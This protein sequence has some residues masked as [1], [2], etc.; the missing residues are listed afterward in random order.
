MLICEHSVFKLWLK[1]RISNLIAC[2][3]GGAAFLSSNEW[4]RANL[5]APEECT[6]SSQLEP[7]EAG[8]S[9]WTPSPPN[10]GPTGWTRSGQTAPAADRRRTTQ[11]DKYQT[12][13]LIQ[14][15]ILIRDSTYLWFGVKLIRKHESACGDASSSQTQEEET[16]SSRCSPDWTR[17][18]TSGWTD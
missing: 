2:H 6:G 3:K 16:N 9:V 17:T 11:Q 10:S 15:T 7:A 1:F 12:T 8:R 13:L 18:Q 14:Q 5:W 4:V